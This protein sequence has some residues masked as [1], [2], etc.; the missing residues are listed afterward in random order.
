MREHNFVSGGRNWNWERVCFDCIF[1][2]KGEGRS[3]GWCRHSANR[4]PPMQG[5]PDG[6]TPSV[7]DTGGC[8]LQQR[9]GENAEQPEGA[10]QGVQ[11]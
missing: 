6:F 8:D 9:K 5:W 10:Y 7:S 4:V 1:L 3:G 2:I 11:P